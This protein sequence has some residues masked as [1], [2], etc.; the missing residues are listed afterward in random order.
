MALAI[1]A[2]VVDDSAL[3]RQILTKTL[4]SD[5]EIEIVGAAPDPYVAREMIKR[6]DPHVITL[7]IEMPRLDGIE[8][9]KKIMTL[10]PMPVVMI[11]SL[12]QAGADATVRALEIGAV[13]FVAKPTHDLTAG[14]ER[15]RT[16]IIT[17]VKAAAR[18]NVHRVT[19]SDTR[20]IAALASRRSYSS[21]EKIIAIGAST[22]GVETLTEILRVM[23]A[24]SPAIL[25]TQ[26]MPAHFTTSFARRLNE[27]C[28]IEV[29]EAMHG[30]RVL[31]GHAYIAPGDRHLELGRSGANYICIV[32]GTTPVTGHCPSVDVLF[33]SVASSA[34]RNSVG[35]ILTGMGKDGA[36]G[37]LAMRQAGA[38]TIGEDEASCVVY[39]MPRV[40]FE[41]GGVEFQLPLSRI[42]GEIL[43]LCGDRSVRV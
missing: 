33:R 29:S 6:F 10:R 21:T 11:S 31:P 43:E 36:A 13:D 38:R 23:P 34:A 32:Q 39:G 42:A 16:E 41:F 37:L 28:A 18:A 17:K 24:D 40:A 26:H 25:V 12:T 27:I 19:P 30:T 2:L 15:M 7:D 22:G 35:V 9:L 5:P 20:K 3:M 1:R 8:F 4:S 14:L